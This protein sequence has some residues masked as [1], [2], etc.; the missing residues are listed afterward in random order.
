MLW[1][2]IGE[3]IL[4]NTDNLCFMESQGDSNEYPQHMFLWRTNI[5]KIPSL[6]VSLS[7]CLAY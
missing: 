3:A 7:A 6:S 1:V 5:N 4:M 2:L